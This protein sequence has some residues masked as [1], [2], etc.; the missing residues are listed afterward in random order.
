MIM[1][2]TIQIKRKKKSCV[3]S[4]SFSPRT[5]VIIGIHQLTTAHPVLNQ[6]IHG[7][8]CFC[9]RHDDN[10]IPVHFPRHGGYFCFELEVP[11]KMEKKG[12]KCFSMVIAN[13][14]AAKFTT[15]AS[16]LR[17]RAKRYTSPGYFNAQSIRLI[18]RLIRKISR[19]NSRRAE[20]LVNS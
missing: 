13:A 11:V 14:I 15:R 12:K 4:R 1:K 7:A 19:E 2:A 20:R 3:I 5:K 6:R 9:V 8:P 17:G 16:K 18:P 10:I